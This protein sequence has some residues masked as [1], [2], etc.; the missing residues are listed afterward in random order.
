M[1]S[2]IITGTICFVIGAIFGIFIIASC[3][4]AKESDEHIDKVFKEK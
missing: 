2:Y 1:L 3:K 4:I